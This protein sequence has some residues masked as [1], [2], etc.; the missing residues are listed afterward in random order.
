M[1]KYNTKSRHTE[2]FNTFLGQLVYSSQLKTTQK[3]V[4]ETNENKTMKQTIMSD[5]FE[6]PALS[7]EEEILF[8]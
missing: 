8:N 4:K 7:G 2:I 6:M 3:M 1:S 5:V